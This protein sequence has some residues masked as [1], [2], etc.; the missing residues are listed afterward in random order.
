ML[1]NPAGTVI[2]G[3]IIVLILPDQRPGTDLLLPVGPGH[4]FLFQVPV[5]V[6]EGNLPVLLDRPMDIVNAVVDTFILRLYPSGHIHLA[7]Q[8]ARIMFSRQKLQ[9]FDQTAGLSACDKAG[10]LHRIHKQLQL[11]Q[12]KVPS[13]H[14]VA[15]SASAVYLENVIAK[16]PQLLYVIIDALA[17][18]MNVVGLQIGDN[19]RRAGRMLLVRI[20]RQQL[21]LLVCRL[22]HTLSLPPGKNDLPAACAVRRGNLSFGRL[23][24]SH[25]DPHRRGNPRHQNNHK[26]QHQIGHK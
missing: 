2:G 6:L 21:Q 23:F 3:Q 10:G 26:K 7:L 12:L 14:V 19:I 24:L 25:C 4:Q 18:G 11:R 15:A 1:H 5:Q 8:L 16:I 9:F 13:A 20:F 22:C 17:L